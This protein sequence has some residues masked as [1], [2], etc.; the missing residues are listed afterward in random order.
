MKLPDG[1]VIQQGLFGSIRGVG[2]NIL[3]FCTGVAFRAEF[4]RR[5][6]PG[7]ALGCEMGNR[8]M[9]IGSALKERK[10]VEKAGDMAW[11]TAAS[12]EARGGKMGSQRA[13]VRQKTLPFAVPRSDILGRRLSL[14]PRPDRFGAPLP[15]NPSTAG[16]SRR[17]KPRGMQ[18]K[19][20]TGAGCRMLE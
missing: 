2:G 6:R 15:Q 13:S 11:H 10:V 20:Y 3:F 12:E 16:F 7:R 14:F 18:S 1:R 9:G 5:S 17:T 19:M 4:H 8:G